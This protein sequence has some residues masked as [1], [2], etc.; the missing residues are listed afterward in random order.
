MK[1]EIFKNPELGPGEIAKYVLLAALIVAGALAC[2]FHSSCQ[3]SSQGIQA[4]GAEESPK[5]EAVKVIDSR[6]VKVSFS[7][8]VSASDGLV[9]KLPQGKGA[10]LDAL[11]ENPAAAKAEP[12]DEGKSV[13]YT[14][15]Q[16]S[17]LGERYQLFSQITDARGNSLTFAVPFDAYNGRVPACALVEVQPKKMKENAKSKKRIAA[18]SP[19]VIIQAL[20]DGNLFGLEL[21]C[22]QNNASFPL[23]PAEVK[24]GEKIALHLKHTEN[25]KEC[26]SELGD[27]LAL[28][29]SGRASDAWRDLYFDAGSD[30]IGGTNDAIF[31]RDRNT[32]KIFDALTYYTASGGK[33]TWNLAAEIQKAIDQNVWKGPA[34]LEGAVQKGT[35]EK[36]PL[37]RVTAKNALGAK[38]AS[39]DDWK[40]AE[41]SV[42]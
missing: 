29:K 23:S 31:L 38:A 32:G 18:E 10:S 33:T 21:Y 12:S 9:T 28:A 42:Y 16:K 25:E 4:L 3:L 11:G 2:A 6:T 39:K 26:A 41:K 14:F 27:N 20:E 13:V 35:S 5:I 19:Y 30:C 8:K 24:A 34:A 22:A 1:R 17:R 40:V 15:S 7:K 36:K 37:T